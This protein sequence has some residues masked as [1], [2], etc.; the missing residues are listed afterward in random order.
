MG[1]FLPT[2]ALAAAAVALLAAACSSTGP[3]KDGTAAASAAPP[4]AKRS[5]AAV[6]DKEAAA[7]QVESRS[8]ALAHYATGVSLE[9]QGKSDAALEEFLL[10]AIGDP[11]NEELVLDVARRLLRKRDDPSSDKALALLRK[12]AEQ[13]SASAAVDALNGAALTQAG[14]LEEALVASRAAIRKD[15]SQIQGWHSAAQVHLQAKRPTDALKV[16]DDA[17]KLP[18]PGL[19]FLTDLADLYGMWLR[20]NADQLEKVKL[21][22]LAVLE[23]AAKLQ[24]TSPAIVQRLAENYRLAG[25]FARAAD[26][27]AGL[28]R[29]FPDQPAL[30]ERLIDLYIRG[31]DHKAATEQLEGVLRQNPGN[32]QAHFLLGAIA[33]EQKDNDKAIERFERALRLDPDLDQA[34]WEL[35]SVRFAQDKNK[36]ALD[37]LARARQRFRNSFVLEFYTGLAHSRQKDYAKAVAHLSTAEEL[38]KKSD[39]A[40]LTHIFYF[41]LGAAHERNKNISEAERYFEQCLKMQPDFAEALNYVGYM[42][43]E[44]G[45]NLD[46]AKVMIEQAVKQDP[47]NAAFL[48]SLGWVLFKLGK[49]KEALDW[50]LKSEKHLK[51]PDATIHD[52]IGDV[53]LTLNKPD[54]AREQWRKALTIEPDNADIRKKLDPPQPK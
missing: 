15:P 24:P 22:L 8:Q 54:L 45:V 48:D 36:E 42:W 31:N 7:A 23:E 44:R 13:P 10:A 41:Q 26:L 53:Y 52:H 21:R 17:A 46:R 1:Q 33:H 51:E 25:E 4:A 37:V 32:A 5:T 20:A 50:L 47:E 40:R 12:A 18:K 49:H 14:R 35:V 38:A 28:L 39:P 2:P 9:L 19:A 11:A 29:R 27:Y 3:R 16:I 6:A 34:Y 30:R 43:A